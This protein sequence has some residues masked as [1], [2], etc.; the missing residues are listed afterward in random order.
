MFGKMERRWLTARPLV[1]GL[2]VLVALTL[3]RVLVFSSKNDLVLDSGEDAYTMVVNAFNRD[4]RLAE[5][6]EHYGKCARVKYIYVVWNDVER[7]IPRRLAGNHTVIRQLNRAEEWQRI[8]SA[9]VKDFLNRAHSKLVYF[10]DDTNAISNRFRPRPF[11][12]EAVFSV[13]DDMLYD[14]DT[15]GA[16]HDV[17]L[18]A[19]QNHPGHDAAD[20]IHSPRAAVGFAPRLIDF[21]QYLAPGAEYESSSLYRPQDDP[22]LGSQRIRY[23]A[24]GTAYT[25]GFHNTL[26][27]TKGAFMSSQ[28]FNRYFAP[29]FEEVRAIIDSHTTGEDLLMSAVM[30]QQRV[31]TVPLHYR[32]IGSKVYH[33]LFTAQ[34]G[35]EKRNTLSRTTE[36]WRPLIMGAILELLASTGQWKSPREPLPADLAQPS[37]MWHIRWWADYQPE[38]LGGWLYYLERVYLFDGRFMGWY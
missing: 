26:F 7:P 22:A 30:W 25:T 27:A 8:G 31:T 34:E 4:D 11:A 12:T 13:D 15:M 35:E 2:A 16:A 33:F 5:S 32:N 21:G 23:Y 38:Q 20:H 17:W 6:I 24:P 28:L 29:E 19:E 36:Q 37:D 10:I 3:W 9:S 14:C 18:D 1:V